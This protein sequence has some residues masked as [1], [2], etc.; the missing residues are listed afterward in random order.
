MKNP[1]KNINR[2]SKLNHIKSNISTSINTNI[3]H[4]FE[5]K[6]YKIKPAKYKLKTRLQSLQIRNNIYN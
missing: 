4:V 6:H 5:K 3:Q 2:A 1:I